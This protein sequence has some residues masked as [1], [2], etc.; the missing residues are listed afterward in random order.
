LALLDI[1]YGKSNLKGFAG[2]GVQHRQDD[3]ATTGPADGSP[4]NAAGMA[5][6]SW[7]IARIVPNGADTGERDLRRPPSNDR[8]SLEPMGPLQIILFISFSG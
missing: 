4:G 8:A 6:S 1:G 5:W 2:G 7:E 3:I